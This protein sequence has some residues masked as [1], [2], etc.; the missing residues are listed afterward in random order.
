[1]TLKFLRCGSIVIR[2]QSKALEHA[3]ASGE[4]RWWL[5]FA[6]LNDVLGYSVRSLLKKQNSRIDNVDEL[7]DG[8]DN[9]ASIFFFKKMVP[10]LIP[11]IISSLAEGRVAALHSFE[12]VTSIAPHSKVLRLMSKKEVW[13]S[14][15]VACQAGLSECSLTTSE[16]KLS[17]WFDYTKHYALAE[18]ASLLDGLCR[19]ALLVEETT[20]VTPTAL[21]AKMITRGVVPHLIELAK[22]D[23]GRPSTMSME[24]LGSISHVKDCRTIIFQ[25]PTG[26]ELVSA[27]LSSK[28]GAMVSPALLLILHL[29]RDEEWRKP[30]SS[31]E[32]RIEL[33]YVCTGQYHQTCTQPEE[34]AKRNDGSRDIPD[35]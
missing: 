1:M 27:A 8:I 4:R 34:R 3:K 33:T 23:V 30:L 28:D 18:V 25:D 20:S 24:A 5:A 12:R 13:A 26:L 10:V 31:V 21:A 2:L 22:A 15:E 14:I 19:R 29:L 17:S 11:A 9:P 32:P 7:D 35:Y 6:H 16:A